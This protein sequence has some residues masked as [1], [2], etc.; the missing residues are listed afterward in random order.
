MR[1]YVDLCALTRPYDR[2]TQERIALEALALAAI[3]KAYEN[4][5]L[6][7]VSSTVL[8]LENSKNPQEDRRV[9]VGDLLGRIR[10]AIAFSGEIRE[11]SRELVPMGFRPLDALHIACAESSRCDQLVRCDDRLQAAAKRAGDRLHVKVVGPL[12]LAAQLEAENLP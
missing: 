2:A 6:E 9:E 12:E 1:V 4:L 8:E 3:V 7:L 10:N 5:R 11:R